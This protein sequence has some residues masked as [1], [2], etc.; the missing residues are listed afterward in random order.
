VA[1]LLASLVLFAP[2]R[3]LAT[4]LAGAT[5]GQLNLQDARGTVWN[6]SAQLVLSGGAD[7][8]DAMA[9]P[10]RVEWRMRPRWLGVALQLRT[11][12]CLPQGAEV[13]AL[14]HGG[15]ARV[16]VADTRSQWP[17]DL[18]KG[19]GTPW[20][21]L[22]PQGQLAIST[23]GLSIEW[24]AGR[25]S[26]AGSAQVDALQMSSRLSTLKPMGSYRLMLSGGDVARMRLE[27]LEGSLLLS[28]QGQW[29]GTRLR[30]EG[31]ASAAPQR[32]DA[33]SNLL[34]IIGGRE[35]ARAII[36]LG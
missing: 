18:L 24:D 20:N 15:G 5:K 30:F 31:E 23:Q 34:N 36:K 25:L 17:A 33:L 3:W 28:G 4:G 27:T 26:V 6:G 8:L 21:T 29:V 2:A 9:L 16:S 19:L 10:S 11:L 32:L 35:G 1:G 22:Q 7:S 13:T 12:C 14:S